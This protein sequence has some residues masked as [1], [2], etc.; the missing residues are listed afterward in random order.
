MTELDTGYMVVLTT[1]E[2]I[3]LKSMESNKSNIIDGI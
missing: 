1:R 3:N 2:K